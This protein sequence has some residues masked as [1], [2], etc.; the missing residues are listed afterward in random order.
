M[1]KIR[2]LF[3]MVML[4]TMTL[5]TGC[6]KDYDQLTYK[7]ADWEPLLAVPLVSATLGMEDIVKNAGG[8]V[9]ADS[10]S[11]L[12]HLVYASDMV[13][14]NAKDYLKIPDQELDTDFDF[15]I[16][17]LQ[18]GDTMILDFGKPYTFSFPDEEIVDSLQIS[19]EFS[20]NL[21][22]N[23]THSGKI[24]VELPF[25]LCGGQPLVFQMNHNYTGSLP[26]L[27]SQT[28][29]LN[30][31]HIYLTQESGSS[32]NIIQ[33][34]YRIDIYGDNNPAPDSF[35]IQ[36]NDKLANL[37]FVNVF[38]KLGTYTETFRDVFSVG[39]F[40]KVELGEVDL[41]EIGLRINV[42][43]SFGLP[44]QITPNEMWASSSVNPPYKVVIGDLPA[45]M[46]ILA[47]SVSGVG[48]FA[49]STIEITSHD[50]IEAFKIAPQLIFYD[51]TASLNP[52]GSTGYNFILDTSEIRFKFEVDLPLI[53]KIGGLELQDTVSLNLD[54]IKEAKSLS[55]RLLVENFFPVEVEFQTYMIN[56]NQTITDSL[57][58]GMTTLLPAGIPGPGQDE[59]VLVP[60]KRQIDITL[61]G[62]R[63]DAFFDASDL[64]I[65]GRLRT[66]GQEL[67]RIYED[68]EIKLKIGASAELQ[69][70]LN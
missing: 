52:P 34:N 27:I 1:M 5:F 51:F 14:A 8:Y 49:H 55:L 20:I 41:Q 43:N 6:L 39:L 26:V 31:C 68:Y 38:G 21:V 25:V 28:I 56:D 3:V 57:F 37:G 33:P 24:E 36:M 16:P 7:V 40:D 47:P 53:G 64:I 10:S 30:G 18:L 19:G 45:T 58:L 42:E 23:L 70:N 22:S 2:Q 35:N 62:A 12:I 44:I 13:A 54:D 69:V 48:S 50:V 59:K 9:L 67:V 11:G 29:D 65:K 32:V 15:Y 4:M 60:G 17:G 61:S 46:D 63:L 66:A